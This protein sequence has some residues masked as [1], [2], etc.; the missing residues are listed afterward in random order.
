[1]DVTR[2]IRSAIKAASSVDT[3]STI[4]P[5][6]YEDALESANMMLAL[7]AT[8]GL[9]VHHVITEQL[10]LVA[11]QASYTIGSSGNFNT[12]RPSRLVGGFIRDSND[13]DSTIEIIDR[14]RYNL[15]SNKDTEGIPKYLYMNPVYPLAT[16][17][18]YFVPDAAYTLSLDS[19][20]PL[21][22]LTLDT[23]LNMPPEYQEAIK[24]NLAVRLAADYKTSPRNDVVALAEES[25]KALSIQ[26]IP[27]AF[28]DG[29]PGVRIYTGAGSIYTM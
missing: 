21:T 14:E 24:W 8:Q 23:E 15:L 12:S 4:D 22:A 6:E 9:V 27:A 29:V 19:L 7:W 20:K 18:V 2:L 28:C 13:T 17:Y 11:G 3:H 25:M 5:A 10:T 26:P 1:M 16:I